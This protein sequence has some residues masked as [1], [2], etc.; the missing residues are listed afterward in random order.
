MLPLVLV[1][2]VCLVLVLLVLPCSAGFPWRHERCGSA[3]PLAAAVVVVCLDPGCAVDRGQQPRSSAHTAV[4]RSSGCPEP[5]PGLRAEEASNAPRN[6]TCPWRNNVLETRRPLD[7]K[8]VSMV[9]YE[10]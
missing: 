1:C 5:P 10:W 2:L 4:D 9:I 8:S 3:W 6:C 7:L